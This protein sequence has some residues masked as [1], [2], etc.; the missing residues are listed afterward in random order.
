MM[1]TEE[2]DWK[3]LRSRIAGWQEAHMEKLNREYIELLSSDG[4][5]SE[6][7]WALDRRIREDR[8][9]AG[10]V[11]EMR[12]S[13]LYENLC[14]L[15]GD[16]VIGLKDLDGFSDELAEPLKTHWSARFN[17]DTLDDVRRT[18]HR[19]DVEQL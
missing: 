2:N 9:S 18:S 19:D 15:L 17:S 12:R 16:G 3:L 6:K 10:V 11:V 14:R 5:A 7:F 13:V 1:Q 4:V 8:R